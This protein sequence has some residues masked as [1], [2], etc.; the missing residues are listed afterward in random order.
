[1]TR[2]IGSQLSRHPLRSATDA[3]SNFPDAARIWHN[4]RRAHDVSEDEII[5]VRRW[6]LGFFAFYGTIVVLLSGLATLAD[7][8]TT[9]DVASIKSTVLH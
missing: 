1:M 9:R 6:R 2:I 7:W 3:S 4:Q 8:P 5:S